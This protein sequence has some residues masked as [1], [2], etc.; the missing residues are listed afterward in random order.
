[1][2]AMQKPKKETGNEG[3]RV[4]QKITILGSK[5]TCCVCACEERLNKL[6]LKEECGTMEEARK[7]TEQ[8]EKKGDRA[9][10]E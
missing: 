7:E 8:V 3:V 10:G 6:H 1:M 9:I 2:K 5:T 4:A